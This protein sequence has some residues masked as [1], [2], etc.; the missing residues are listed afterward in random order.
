MRE[1]TLEEYMAEGERLFGPE[2]LDWRF[3]CPSCGH[4]A[5]P[6]DWKAAGAPEGAVAFSCVGRWTCSKQELFSKD[7]GPCNYTGGGLFALNPVTVR[8]GDRTYN[9]FEFASR[10][11]TKEGQLHG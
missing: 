9:V 2:Q 7:G 6:R 11:I 1:L 5:S 4:V 8:A 10:P 3:V